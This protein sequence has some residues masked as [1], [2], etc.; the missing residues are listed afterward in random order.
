MHGHEVI[1]EAE[2][3]LGIGVPDDA[4]RDA[5]ALIADT[6]DEVFAK[7]IHDRKSQRAAAVVLRAG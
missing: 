7:C 1:V 2:A 3:G 4:Y 6:P 5:G